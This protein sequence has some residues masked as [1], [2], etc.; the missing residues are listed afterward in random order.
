METPYFDPVLN[1][2]YYN[3]DIFRVMRAAYNRILYHRGD[4]RNPKVRKYCEWLE[5]EYPHIFNK[6]K[7][8]SEKVK[9]VKE[10]LQSSLPAGE[11]KI[12]V[13]EEGKEQQNPANVANPNSVN[14]KQSPVEKKNNPGTEN[15]GP[16]KRGPGRKPKAANLN[17][18][19]NPGT[20]ATTAQDTAAPNP[21]KMKALPVTTPTASS[22]STVKA[23]AGRAS[24]GTQRKTPLK[25]IYEPPASRIKPLPN[26]ITKTEPSII[27]NILRSP[28]SKPLSVS[29]ANAAAGAG[30][31]KPAAV[32]KLT[33]TASSLFPVRTYGPAKPATASVAGGAT[34]VSTIALAATP[35]APTVPSTP[36]AVTAAATVLTANSVASTAMVTSPVAAPTM[37]AI[38]TS[39][40]T[41]TTAVG[42]PRQ[43]LIAKRNLAGQQIG[44]SGG[45]GGNAVVVAQKG[46]GGPI[47]IRAQGQPGQAA[48]SQAVSL[49]TITSGAGNV[50]TAT[51]TIQLSP[52]G[53]P[54]TVLNLRGN[55]I[56]SLGPNNQVVRFLNQQRIQIVQSPSPGQVQNQ[57]QF[58][59]TNLPV[60]VRLPVSQGV[61]AAASSQPTASAIVAAANS[62]GGGI[63]LAQRSPRPVTPSSGVATTTVVARS[64]PIA[65]PRVG[66]PLTGVATIKSP[67]AAAGVRPRAITASQLRAAG[68][69]LVRQVSAGGGVSPVRVSVSPTIRTIAVPATAAAS[70]GVRASGIPATSLTASAMVRPSAAVAGGMAPRAVHQGSYVR[71]TWQ[72]GT[73]TAPGTRLVTAVRSPASASVLVA[74]SNIRFRRATPGGGTTLIMPVQGAGGQIRHVSIAQSAVSSSAPVQ[75]S[76]SAISSTPSSPQQQQQQ[77]IMVQPELVIPSSVAAASAATPTTTGNAATAAAASS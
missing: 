32:V 34:A 18:S 11:K 50:S 20:P 17:P 59:T 27:P 38:A 58:T 16:E 41:P 22:L 30:A 67:T 9:Q 56:R 51:G 65:T 57:Q 24:F 70:A 33:P 43:I 63:R 40:G 52:Q 6:G 68:G 54:M 71:P 62:T 19:A 12:I 72:P 47:V 46:G 21:K 44:V 76:Q 23:R 74:G 66:K 1:Q 75:V 29:A 45:P 28:S 61:A 5:T 48:V 55:L 39:P 37:S 64:S 36:S 14:S 42:Q 4:R 7:L 53:V 25:A 73:P 77:Q 10:E 15:P 8:E 2:A 3:K 13:V 26:A 69:T 49:A 35:A 31:K 60:T